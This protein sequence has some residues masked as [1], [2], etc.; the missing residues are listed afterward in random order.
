MNMT[1]RN[2]VSMLHER[3]QTSGGPKPHFQLIRATGTP[4]APTFSY[5]V[6]L[7]RLTS[8]GSGPS[9][10]QAKNVAA[11]NMLNNMDKKKVAESDNSESEVI[12]VAKYV[13]GEVKA[14]EL[15]TKTMVEVLEDVCAKH[16]Y[17][18][19][20]YD[21]EHGG[22]GGSYSIICCVGDVRKAGMGHTRAGARNEAAKRMLDMLRSMLPTKMPS[23]DE[24]PE[25]PPDQDESTEEVVESLKNLKMEQDSVKHVVVKS[26]REIVSETRNE[27]AKLRSA[28]LR[29]KS[30]DYMRMLV[31]LGKEQKFVVACVQEKHEDLIMCLVQLNTVPVAVSCAI[32]TELKTVEKNAARDML[33]YL[34]MLT[35]PST[36][37]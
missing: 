35:T 13:Q 20:V 4:N 10:K 21:D 1:H 15:T 18:A 16:G 22:G 11:Q 34:K 37:S 6:S 23:T 25:D 32:G 12:K 3:V 30:Q 36:S 28:Y 26:P 31:E 19:P 9:K 29:D 27:L 17:R 5:Q 2:P 7:G 8:L 33:N 24:S 14:V